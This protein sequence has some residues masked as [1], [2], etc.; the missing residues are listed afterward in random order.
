[1]F[2][3]AG[4]ASRLSTTTYPLGS[5][6]TF[7][8]DAD[9]NV[10]SRKTRAGPI[11]NF[12][13]DTL[14][15]LLTKTPPSPAPSVTYSYDLAGRLI[16]ARDT[17]SSAIVAAAPP[18]GTPVQ[19]AAAYTYDVMNRPTGVSWT[20]APT[21]A[22]PTAS[23]VS[24]S[25]SYS[26]AN[27]RI[28]QT[29]SDNSWVNYPAAT[30]ST[31]SYTSDALNR[32]TAVGAVT[33]S[34]DG[35]GNLT[36]DG[37]FTL[38]YDA[39]NRLTSASGAS[40]T[41]SYAYDAQGRR[42]SKTVN[43]TTTVFVT[44][45]DNREVLEYD[46]GSGAI[47]KWYAYALGPNAVLNQMNVVAATRATLLPDILGSIIASQDSSSGTLI[48]VSYLPYGKSGSGGPFGFTGQRIDVET[49][50]LY[51]YRARHYSP[52]WGR[53]LQ[54]D[55]IGYAGGANLYAYVNNDPLNA[56]D[57]TGKDCATANG[58]ISCA[59]SNYQFSVP[60]ANS[61][62]MWPFNGNDAVNFKSS[63]PGYHT[64]STPANQGNA[65][66]VSP[67]VANNYI[68]NN[69][70]P[71]TAN[72]ATPAGTAN[73]ATPLF[74]NNF[75]VI[76]PVISYT[77][78]NQLN[79]NPIMVNV[80]LPGHPLYPGIVVREVDV[81]ANG[82]TVINNWGEGT[83][84]FQNPNSSTGFASQYINGVWNGLYPHK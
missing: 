9:S 33:P 25:H 38:G 61:S 17:T 42:K 36:S 24:F 2:L 12:S 34:Y 51:Y 1:L 82:G 41:A 62:L 43:G 58:T 60:A 11:I 5:T 57:P 72:P 23:S 37:T 63:D 21:A 68:V 74:G 6:E 26:K 50:G 35:N 81:D 53:F 13:Y 64:Y 40:N 83:S 4:K 65:I 84:A 56:T 71:G 18:G 76:S 73:D 16:A 19:Y 27:Q 78:T 15:R 29:I 14:N 47:Q 39:E 7:T 20:P 22:A 8:Y 3:L 75:A 49:S 69:P 44:D 46:G 59:S 70:V 30:P 80:T 52:A 28:G 10:L 66:N 45:A 79:G 67:A 55:P 54:V 31:V 32:Y 77:T 48:K